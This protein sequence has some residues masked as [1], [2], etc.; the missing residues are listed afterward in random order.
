M[1]KGIDFKINKCCQRCGRY[2]STGGYSE[3]KFKIYNDPKFHFSKGVVLCD[4]CIMDMI[5]ELEEIE[6][7]KIAYVH[8]IP[9]KKEEVEELI[10]NQNT[11]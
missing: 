7:N 5:N 1:S 11:E 10:K 4:D 3:D 2:G 8:N 6:K 9:L